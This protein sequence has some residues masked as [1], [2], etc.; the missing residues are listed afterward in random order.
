MSSAVKS[1]TK[2]SSLDE[3][4]RLRAR[5]WLG[6]SIGFADCRAELLDELAAAGQLRRL[7]RGQFSVRRGDAHTQVGM[8][9]AGLLESVALRADGH[10]HLL[11]L[12][13]PGM[14]HG[15]IGAVDGLPHS[16]DVVARQDSVLLAIPAEAMQRLRQREPSI[17]LA[18]ERQITR[19]LRMLFERLA[20]DPAVPL[21]KRAAAMLATLATLY[22]H[23]VG[24]GVKLDAKLSQSDLADWLGMSRQRVNFALKQLEGEGLIALGFVEMKIIDIDGLEA[25]AQG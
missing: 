17:V 25:R 21:E 9:V 23:R 7:V 11:G 13:L 6:R 5:H 22:G 10:R 15:L 16:H 18:C 20:A 3:H 14:F 1:T 2:P 24:A 8:V 4:L 12:L 19:R